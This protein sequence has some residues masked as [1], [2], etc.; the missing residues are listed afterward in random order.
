LRTIAQGMKAADRE[1]TTAAYD[2]A[3]QLQ[4][5]VMVDPATIAEKLGRSAPDAPFDPQAFLSQTKDFSPS[6]LKTMFGP[7]GEQA[8]S[9]LR[10][11]SRR[12][13]DTGALNVGDATR[14]G[15]LERQGWRQL[16]RAFIGGVT[17]LLKS[18]T[19]LTSAAAAGG[20]GYAGG[21]LTGAIAAG[22]TAAT[23]AGG[24]EVSRVLSARSM[25][26]PR[27]ARWL[28]Q[29]ADITS[30]KGAQEQTRKLSVIIAREPALA[31]ELKPVYDFLEN[32]LELPL[33][34]Q[35]DQGQGNNE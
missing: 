33:A 31:Q 34:A 35:P 11:L 8:V 17:G 19:G 21:G 6:A 7:G 28:A 13:L 5:D 10:L 26:S 16:A 32:R 24:R 12:L 30:K 23:I 9:D 14:A 20:T 4:P 2:A 22:G 25:M 29:T 15:Y 3:R 18:G 27:L 1:G